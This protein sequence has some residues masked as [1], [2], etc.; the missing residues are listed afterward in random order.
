MQALQGKSVMGGALFAASPA[1]YFV[2]SVIGRVLMGL[3][4]GLIFAA[5]QKALPKKEKLTCYIAAFCAPF[6]NTVFYMGLLVAIFYNS[7]FVQNLAAKKGATNPLMFIVLVVGI[8]A[9]VEWCVCCAVAGTVS[10]PV[11]KYMKNH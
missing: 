5:L 7:E 10:L 11:R 2:V 8:Q 9:V 1:G 3:C 4:V 6:L